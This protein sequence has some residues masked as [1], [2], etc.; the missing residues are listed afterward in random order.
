M[1][2]N[3]PVIFHHSNYKCY[4]YYY[5][6][7]IMAGRQFLSWWWLAGYDGM[8]NYQPIFRERESF[9][10]LSGSLGGE[11]RHQQV[12]GG[13][14]GEGG[15]ASFSFSLSVLYFTDRLNNSFTTASRPPSARPESSKL[16][17]MEDTEG[18]TIYNVF[19]NV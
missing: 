2:V 10:S 5:A 19:I 18:K 3:C 15:E 4:Y 6:V 11:L 13:K 8:K 7:V 12:P 16:S 17:R 14:I 1:V 9:S